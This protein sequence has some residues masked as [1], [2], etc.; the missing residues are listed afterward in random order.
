MIK[1]FEALASRTRCEV[2]REENEFKR[3]MGV[4]LPILVYRFLDTF[5][6][7]LGATIVKLATEKGLFTNEFASNYSSVLTAIIKIISMLIACGAILKSFKGENAVI[8]SKE[9]PKKWLIYSIMLGIT[10]SLF[11]NQIF[12]RG[13]FL[14]KS[15]L[16][17]EVAARQYSL[18][19]GLGILVYGIM[20][21]LAEELLYRGIVYNRLRRSFNLPYALI[22]SSLVFGVMHG[23]I[24]QGIYGCLLGFLIAWIYERFGGFIYPYLMHASANT[25]IYLLMQTEDFRNVMMSTPS[26]IL[27]GISLLIILIIIFMDKETQ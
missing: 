24:I 3:A 6:V 9:N 4:V 5:F 22:F 7:T 25:C 16:F 23:N 8:I 10:A 17:N 19:M 11:V 18:S 15:E 21:P 1:G 26:I 13:G 12:Y 2:L 20:A 27:S 14:G